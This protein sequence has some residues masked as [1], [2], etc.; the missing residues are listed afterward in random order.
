MK[1]RILLLLTY[2]I[3]MCA[4]SSLAQTVSVNIKGN[5]ITIASFINQ[6]ESQTDY[7]FVYS[8]SEINIHSRIYVNSGRMPLK[9][10]LDETLD[11]FGFKYMFDGNYIIITKRKGTGSTDTYT[12]KVIGRI[13]DTSGSPIIGATVIQ[14]G[15]HNATVTYF[16]GYFSIEVPNFATLTVSYI[17]YISTDVS[18]KGKSNVNL[19]L[20]EDN[21]L[22][23]EVVVVGYGTIKKKDLTGSVSVVKGTDISSRHTTQLS[24][25][26][27]GLIPG[28]LVSR[29]NDAPGTTASINIRGVTTIS[30]SSPLV[31]VDGIPGEIDQVNPDDVEA[32]SVLKDAASA[33]IYGSRAAA[34]VIL[35]TT[36]RAECNDVQL[37]YNFEYGWMK[38]TTL[39]KYTN[40]TRY[41][42]M[43][44]EL[45]Y[46][47]NNAGGK[48]QVY[49]EDMINN[50]MTNHLTNPDQYPVEDWQ[51]AILKDS[52]PRQTHIISISG[53]GNIVRTKASFRYDK[54]DGLYDNDGY[55]RYMFSVN[56]D[57]S[58]NKYIEAHLDLNFNRSSYT[59]PHVNPLNHGFRTIPP[60]Y[61]IRWSNGLW[62][63]VKDGNN[64]IAMLED[65]GT[66]NNCYNKLKGKA[67][68]DIKPFA[69][70]KLSAVIAP[71][72]NFDKLKAFTR[73][74][75]F[76]YSEDP[77]TVRGYMMKFYDTSLYENRNDSHD[78]TAQLIADYSKSF[79]KHS[80]SAMIG[81]EDYYA[82]WE[83][84]AASREQYE[85]D[86]YPY[87]DLGS[88]DYRNNSG[89]AYDYSYM[90]FFGRVN[91]CYDNKY[92]FEFNFRRDGSSRFS[93]NNRWANFPSFSL[94]WVLSEEKFMKSIKWLSELKLRIS[95]GLLGN[96]RIGSYYP[97]QSAINFSN[98]LFYINND[99][100]S[101]KTGAQNVYAV[102]D[103]TWE[104]T[105]TWDCGIDAGLF[106]G[107]LAFTGDFYRKSTKNMLLALEIPKYIGY[108]NPQVNAGRMHTTGYDLQLTWKDN[109]GDFNY[110]IEV[111][112]S[113]FVSKMGNLSGTEFLGDQIK[114]DGSEFNEWYGYICDGIYQTQADVD[115]SPKLN[116]NIKVGDLK[117]RD[118]SGPDG[119]PDGKIS[120]EYDRVLLGG[121]LPRY[122]F[123]A[124]LKASYMG[125]DLGL[126][127]QGVGKQWSRINSVMIEGLTDNWG[128][129]P[130]LIDGKYWSSY[131]TDSQNAHAEYPRLTRSNK[132]ANMCLSDFWLFN[133][134]Y[135]RLKNIT[136]GYTL[137]SAITNKIYMKSLRFYVSANDLFSLSGYPKGWDPEVGS[138]GYPITKSLLL[139]MSI[140]F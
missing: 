138:E 10:C 76:T 94:G 107:K 37:S 31:I 81:Y 7:L 36:K 39:P 70:L 77:S 104:T 13:S 92:L 43:T 113:D 125:F 121:S 69:G 67:E 85:V 5:K 105:K 32:I 93:K 132:D 79:G 55:G 66:N 129:F 126:S 9:K 90:S 60:I 18:V 54:N 96:E 53:G 22:L 87:L 83:N 117:Y 89:N 133:G 100:L 115:N 30:D 63:D 40:A 44:N 137:P 14:K 59:E 71:T 103:I 68:L 3:P 114:R 109:T 110:S 33:S 16:D 116:K 84:L 139:G 27:Q 78:L 99:I 75:P 95:S 15:T 58:I 130:E 41:M 23:D 65:G 46:N 11:R 102:R 56:N 47:D 124:I 62:G 12:R 20:R 64:V 74:I 108:D 122:M 119:V 123:G 52:A 42:Q 131:N 35:I 24:T 4:I 82:F 73:R 6:V 26:L 28:V 38:P 1:I 111:N 21:K 29:D 128:N 80:V 57:F 19:I 48:Y 25:A 91:Y 136:L 50:W 120:S 112:F 127:I 118:I 86:N 49:S 140:T 45:R 2:L 88:Q 135:V 101:E 98:T 51:D 97:Y 17:G 72:Y 8:A 106:N 134:R 61:A 34:G